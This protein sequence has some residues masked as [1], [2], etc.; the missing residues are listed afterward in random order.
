MK[1]LAD[2]NMDVAIVDR[3]RQEGHQVWYVVEMEP[4]IADN[5]V[6]ALANLEG[7]IL[8]TADRDFG[9]L[10]FRLRYITTGIILIRLAGLST[11]AKSDT[12]AMI[13][14]EHES[15]Q[16]SKNSRVFESDYCPHIPGYIR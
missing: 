4:G 3:L 1:F 12:V 8:I 5:E 16:N 14:Q 10:V 11:L 15:D 6:P 7:A 9:E 13:I 2:E